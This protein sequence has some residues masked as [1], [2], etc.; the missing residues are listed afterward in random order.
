MDAKTLG[1]HALQ[2]LKALEKLLPGKAVLAVPR[3]IHDLKALLAFSQPEDPA[4][5]EAAGDGL[6]D[7]AQRLLQKVDVGEIIQID[8]RPQLCRQLVLGGGGLVGGEHDLLPGEAA[9]IRQHQL[10]EG[11]AVRAAALLPQNLQ[12]GGGGGGLNGK[13][14]LKA[15]VPSKGGFQPSGG[16][17]DAL[18][19]IEVEGGG[20]LSGDGGELF[21]GHKGLFHNAG[22]ISL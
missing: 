21:K 2:L 20:V 19:V 18:F 1:P 14:L 8:D 12:N 16:L 11:G 13:I 22:L 15:R 7:I 17:P 4:G 6:G 5:V 9:F 3:G 10:G